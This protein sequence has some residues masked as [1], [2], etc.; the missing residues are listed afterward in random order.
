[1]DDIKLSACLQVVSWIITIWI[2][3]SLTIFLLARVLGGEVSQDWAYVFVYVFVSSLPGSIFVFS[4]FSPNKYVFRCMLCIFFV[5]VALTNLIWATTDPIS[6]LTDPISALK[7]LSRALTDLRW[8]LAHLISALTEL[9]PCLAET[10]RQITGR[11]SFLLVC[12]KCQFRNVFLW[13]FSVILSRQVTSESSDLWWKLKGSSV[14]WLCSLLSR[15]PS[16]RSLVWLDIP[17]FP[18]YLSRLS[19]WWS[20]NLTSFQRW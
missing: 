9:L 11:P 10:T 16:V 3:G 4:L 17:F 20:V 13:I 1:M 18:L 7:H 14:A 6:A 2:F 8:P 19:S 15:S 12:H 5:G